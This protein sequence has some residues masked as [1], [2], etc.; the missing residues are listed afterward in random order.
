MQTVGQTDVRKLIVTFCNFTKSYFRLKNA[1]NVRKA[2]PFWR[3]RVIAAILAT[4]V[5]RRL[6]VTL[7]T[8]ITI[9]N[10]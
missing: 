5:T 2:E 7:V 10:T 4:N 8:K 3:F 6:L 9:A 1:E